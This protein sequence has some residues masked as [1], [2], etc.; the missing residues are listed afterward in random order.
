MSGKIVERKCANC[1]DKF[2]ARKADVKRGWGRFCS[3][4]CKATRQEKKTGQYAAFKNKQ[5]FAS[6]D[7]GF[8]GHGQS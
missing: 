8:F 1:G 4:S 7:S 6:H 5:C 3:K 2:L